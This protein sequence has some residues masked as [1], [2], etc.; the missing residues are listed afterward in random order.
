MQ[1]QERPRKP[2][3]QQGGL[4]VKPGEQQKAQD[5]NDLRPP[6]FDESAERGRRAGQTHG[7]QTQ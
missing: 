2:L 6:H 4:K 7:R 5:S 1:K 3:D